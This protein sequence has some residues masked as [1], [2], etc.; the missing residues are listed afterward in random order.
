LKPIVTA[1]AAAAVATTTHANVATIDAAAAAI[2]TGA[3]TAA[4]AMAT[5][6]TIMFNVAVAP[7]TAVVYIPEE[8]CSPSG[9]PG[10]CWQSLVH[11]ESL[12]VE[13]AA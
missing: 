9:N 1:A 10:C 3:A 11:A 8:M 5:A 6:A 4:G 2:N 12:R 7:T 13:G